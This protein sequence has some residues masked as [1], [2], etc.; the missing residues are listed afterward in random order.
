MHWSKME[1]DRSN[2]V[3][4]KEDNGEYLVSAESVTRHFHQ[5]RDKWVACDDQNYKDMMERYHREL[6]ER[7][8]GR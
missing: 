8:Q 7:E 1:I 2:V 3:G 6:C 4:L 5:A